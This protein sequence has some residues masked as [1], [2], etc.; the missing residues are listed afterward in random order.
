MLASTKYECGRGN[1][2]GPCL[3]VG[4]A[5]NVPHDELAFAV[6]S[7]TTNKSQR[8]DLYQ[9]II[10]KVDS[11]LVVIPP[12]TI[13]SHGLSAVIQGALR[14]IIEHF[15]DR[16]F[17]YDG[18]SKF[19]IEHRDFETLV[20]ADAKIISVSCASIIAKHTL[21]NLMVE[22]HNQY[23][24]YNLIKNSGYATQEHIAAISKYGYTQ[25]HRKSYRIRQLELENNSEI[26]NILF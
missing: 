14:E 16:K 13:D 9:R 15:H 2:F 1:L 5:L 4:V 23:P 6:D 22:Y 25:D 12:S 7:K 20:A 3:F 10:D 19:G 18:N 17:I 11:H 21:D 26:S 8:V 24:N